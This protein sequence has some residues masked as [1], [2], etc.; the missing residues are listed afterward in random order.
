MNRDE[1]TYNYLDWMY[2]LVC[3]MS[4]SDRLSYHKLFNFLYDIEFT[5]SI[6]MDANRADD[7]V[8]LRYRFGYEQEYNESTIRDYLNTRP[9]SVLEMLIALSIRCEDHIMS[10]PEIGNRTGQWFWNMMRNLGLV[11]MNDINF[12]ESHVGYV[13]QRF[14]HRDYTRTGD[15][16]LF[17]VE[18]P[19]NDMRKVE[20]WY[21]MCWYLDTFI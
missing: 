1:L 15:G 21:Q 12:D 20:I 6:D 13:V 9:C 5:Y 2:Q 3:T 17:T 16:G 14:L 7:G 4:S 19:R 18:H 10:D 8:A 11:A